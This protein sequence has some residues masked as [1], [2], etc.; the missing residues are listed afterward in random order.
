MKVDD[1]LAAADRE[2]EKDAS[3]VDVTRIIRQIYAVGFT[4][5]ALWV[6]AGCPEA[7]QEEPAQ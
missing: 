7:K 4:S 1:I 6:A 3:R 2:Y 5:G